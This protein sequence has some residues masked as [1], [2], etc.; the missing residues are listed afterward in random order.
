[1]SLRIHIK[2]KPLRYGRTK[3]F[4]KELSD[5]NSHTN[6]QT[7]SFYIEIQSMNG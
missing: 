1:M 3:I 5:R 4:N 6:F 7:M 2:I